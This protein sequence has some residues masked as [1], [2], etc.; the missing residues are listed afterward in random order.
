MRRI[1]VGAMMAVA[2]LAAASPAASARQLFLNAHA[3]V[4]GSVVVTWHGDPARGCAEAGLCGYRGSIALRPG[5]GSRLSLRVSNGRVRDGYVFFD[6]GDGTQSAA[7][8]VSREENGEPSGGCIDL[9]RDDAAFIFGA[10]R[11]GI[12]VGFDGGGLTTGRCAGPP[13]ADVLGQVPARRLSRTRLLRGGAALDF[14]RR[15]PYAAGHFSGTLT[16]TLR[17]RIGRPRVERLPYELRH[18]SLPPPRPTRLVR[19]A[20]VHAR[21]RVTGVA[22]TFSVA[23][24]GLPAPGCDV[25]DGC[26]LAGTSEWAIL[27]GDGTVLVEAAA[28]VRSGD[29]GLSGALAAIRRGRGELST[30]GFLTHAKGTTTTALSRDGGGSCRDHAGVRAP[31]IAGSFGSRQLVLALGGREAYPAG[32]DL[33]HVGC[34]GPTEGDV[35]RAQPIARAHLPATALARRQLVV[36][37]RG[38]GRF[39]TPGYS[40]ARSGSFTLGLRRQSLRVSYGHRRV[41]R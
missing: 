22:G 38:D 36:R 31:G 34:P 1:A 35:L 33:V 40:G 28:R 21:Y 32:S 19:V 12:R 10:G 37:L 7:V 27:R 41:A 30:I 6:S 3:N 29:R 26:G 8:R 13:L 23:F 20:R 5:T 14:S 25:L 15:V 16:S 9:Y 17:M 2:V 39:T 18:P 24:K 11:G 4:T